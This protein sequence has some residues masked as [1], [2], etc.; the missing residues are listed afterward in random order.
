VSASGS[1]AGPP[2]GQPVYR[3]IAG[4]TQKSDQK[5]EWKKRKNEVTQIDTLNP[6][7]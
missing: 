4:E 7:Q 5:S 1:G 2:K 6:R 3:A